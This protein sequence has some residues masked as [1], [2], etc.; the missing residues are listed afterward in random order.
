MTKKVRAIVLIAVF[1]LVGTAT[2]KNVEA[3]V[4][5]GFIQICCPPPCPPLCP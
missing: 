4:V 3:S 1:I 5:A 2:Q